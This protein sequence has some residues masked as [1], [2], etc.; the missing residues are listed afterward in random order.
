MNRNVAR[1]CCQVPKSDRLC[2]GAQESIQGL[3]FPSIRSPRAPAHFGG[4]RRIES[5]NSS[6]PSVADVRTWSSYESC[7]PI[8][9]ISRCC[10]PCAVSAAEK[11]TANLHTVTNY[12]ALAMFT[13]RRDR[14]NRAFKAVKCVPRTGSSQFE[15]FVIIV[16]TNF[17]FCHL[18]PLDR[19]K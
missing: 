4:T 7:C 17:A 16:A 15:G 6:W 3:T 9:Y 11:A 8:L 19:A 14:L 18:P 5:L 10:G 12:S 2:I 13:D 1:S